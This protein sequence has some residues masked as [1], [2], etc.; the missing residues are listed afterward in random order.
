V[1]AHSFNYKNKS[2]S[3]STENELSRAC[4]ASKNLRMWDTS[5]QLPQSAG[6]HSSG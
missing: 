5:F 2:L 4:N 3:C 6:S 1:G